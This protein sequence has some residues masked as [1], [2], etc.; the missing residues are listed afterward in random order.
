MDRRDE[1]D[2]KDVKL[3]LELTMITALAA[4]STVAALVHGDIFFGMFFAAATGIAASRLIRRSVD[5]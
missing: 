5:L 2:D 3:F 4:V 1:L